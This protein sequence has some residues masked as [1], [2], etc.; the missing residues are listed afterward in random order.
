MKPYIL[1]LILILSIEAS[2]TFRGTYSQ[3]FSESESKIVTDLLNGQEFTSNIICIC[4]LDH[5][6]TLTRLHWGHN[7]QILLDYNDVSEDMI[8]KANNIYIA[9]NKPSLYLLILPKLHKE[10]VLMDL[11]RTVRKVDQIGR[12]IIMYRKYVDFT[13]LPR[14]VYNTYMLT[15][16]D[17]FDSRFAM[18]EVCKY[19][20]QGENIIEQSNSWRSNIGFEK[21]VHLAKSFK[22]SFSGA[23]IN[24][25]LLYPFGSNAYIKGHGAEGNDI[26]D[27]SVYRRWEHL[28]GMLHAKFKY[29]QARDGNLLSL[30]MRNGT[31]VGNMKDLHNGVVDI[32]GG[33][34]MGTYVRYKASD[35]STYTLRWDGA[36]VITFEPDKGIQWYGVVQSFDSTVWLCLFISPPVVGIFLYLLRRFDRK[37]DREACI[38]D[39]LWDSMVIMAWES[40]QCLNVP[41]SICILLSFYMFAVLT[42]VSAYM[43]QMAG[44]LLA[45]KHLNPPIN[46]FEQIWESDLKILSFGYITGRLHDYFR[47]VPNFNENII[48]LDV[49]QGEDPYDLAMRK[50]KDNPNKFVLFGTVSEYMNHINKYLPT[51]KLWKS[52][53]SLGIK[54]VHLMFLPSYPEKEIVNRK[55]TLMHDMGIIPLLEHRF[56]YS[57][58]FYAR[59]LRAEWL[60]PIEKLK[61]VT[62]QELKLAFYFLLVSHFLAFLFFSMGFLWRKLPPL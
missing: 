8:R 30:I 24:V 36:R 15:P 34:R 52:G 58:I 39:D 51:A 10:Q 28:A 56:Y 44:C 22:G 38:G 29:I 45:P 32:I 5:I 26:L 23:Q 13:D 16:H 50:F 19:C 48:H 21:P 11:I 12:I 6:D 37:P 35:F 1:L 53:D 46:K 31:F 40:I 59:G 57:G 54:F 60:K 3:P 55:L 42:V 61:L 41:T 33:N 2:P 47:E 43:G 4:P 9:D 20:D 17:N 62:L 14:A 7:T 25:G 18:F 49:K 27:G